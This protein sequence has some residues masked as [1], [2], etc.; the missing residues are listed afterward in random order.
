MYIL[1]S[2]AYTQHDQLSPKSTVTWVGKAAFSTYTLS[3]T[4][5]A[6]SGVLSWLEG[7]IQK[8]SLIMDM[9][10]IQSDIPQLTDHLRSAD[11]FEEEEVE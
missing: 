2:S 8:A 10:S 11:F 1:A 9:Q 6:K 4:I 5:E 3:G 7:R